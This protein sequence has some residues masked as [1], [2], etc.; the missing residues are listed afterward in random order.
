MTF[1]CP[2]GCPGGLAW[3]KHSRA[4]VV[5]ALELTTIYFFNVPKLIYKK[6]F[7]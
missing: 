4:V 6:I 3:P 7:L 1:A 5:V 2:S